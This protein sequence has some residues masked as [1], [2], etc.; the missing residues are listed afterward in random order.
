LFVRRFRGRLKDRAFFSAM[1]ARLSLYPEWTRI[2]HPPPPP[3][4]PD[5]TGS[6]A[7]RRNTTS[8]T[9]ENK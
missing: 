3:P 5:E 2:L 4:P 8:P 1:D 9:S 7:E 6:T